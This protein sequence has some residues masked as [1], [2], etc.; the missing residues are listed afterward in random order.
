[1]GRTLD[2]EATYKR[3]RS[4]GRAELETDYVLFRGDFRVKLPF[5]AITATS[6]RA[7]VLTLRSA[8]GTLALLLGDRAEKWAA[9]I[10]SPKS[11][12]D[13][14]GVKAGQRV[15]LDRVT[16]A[17]FIDE[18]K[19]A[20]AD[21]SARLRKNS[22]VVF[23]LVESAADLRNIARAGASLAPDG[24][25]WAIRRK[26]VA[27]ASEALTM[28]AGKAAGLVDVKVVRFSETHTAEK[29][30]IPKARRRA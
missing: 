5:G 9:A 19:T 7:G 13:K 17:A 2:C 11:R 28:A 6:V 20:G 27:E 3:R 4:T 26:G 29:F 10:R 12:L 16:D 18:L 21:L 25:V 23:V 30:V 15:S 1:M 8:E 22:D 24:A 14:I